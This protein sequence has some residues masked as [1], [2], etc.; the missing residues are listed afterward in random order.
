MLLSPGAP[1][2]PS[3]AVALVPAAAPAC[4]APPRPATPGLPPSAAPAHDTEVDPA[5]ESL[6]PVIEIPA[7]PLAHPPLVAE[8]SSPGA[9]SAQPKIST[10]MHQIE[11]TTKRRRTGISQQWTARS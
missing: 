10:E 4:P 5:P 9:T 2:P 11:T 3:P 1:A 7:P 8:L 6:A